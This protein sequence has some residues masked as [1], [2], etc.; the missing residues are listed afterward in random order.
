M[1]IYVPPV[2]P[3]QGYT[4]GFWYAVIAAGLY[5]ICSMSLM[6]NMLGY[7]L[8]HYT[9]R[10]ALT[11]HQRTLILQTTLFFLW[12]AAGGAMFAKI[13]KDLGQ[14]NWA[15]VDGVRPALIYIHT[16]I[17]NPKAAVFL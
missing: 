14:Q 9:Q 2:A 15:F 6:V 1:H 16:R 12:L 7:F 17:A 13:E 11:D 8:G 3:Y 5:L 4:Q 10:F